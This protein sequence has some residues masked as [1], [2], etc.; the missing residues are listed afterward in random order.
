V[1]SGTRNQYTGWFRRILRDP[2][3]AAALL[4]VVLFVFITIILPI[5]AMVGASVSS[6][7]I[8]LF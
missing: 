5:L 6:D 4:L 7:G 2:V 1:L 3:L 8:A